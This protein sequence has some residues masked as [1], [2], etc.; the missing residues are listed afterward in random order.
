MNIFSPKEIPKEIPK[1]SSESKRKNKKY[2]CYYNDDSDHAEDVS[3]IEDEY[4]TDDL[5]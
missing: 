1:P 3:D 4:D 5:A 2:Q